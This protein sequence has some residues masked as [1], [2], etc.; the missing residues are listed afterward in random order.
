MFIALTIDID[1]YF[2]I[3]PKMSPQRDDDHRNIR[4][5]GLHGEAA[6]KGRYSTVRNTANGEWF[7]RQR[8]V[9]SS[10]LVQRQPPSTL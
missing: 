3:T 2:N 1:N 10:K 9:I 8:V 4:I 7:P 5:T 6:R